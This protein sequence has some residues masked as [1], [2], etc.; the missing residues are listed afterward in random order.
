MLEIEV[1][2]MGPLSNL[3]IVPDRQARSII[4]TGTASGLGQEWRRAGYRGDSLRASVYH[5]MK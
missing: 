1:V 2:K 3:N 5:V 4:V